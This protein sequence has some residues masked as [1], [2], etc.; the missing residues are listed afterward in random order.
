[1]LF[2]TVT[3]LLCKPNFIWMWK[4]LH[5]YTSGIYNAIG[6]KMSLFRHRPTVG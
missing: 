3:E 5:F 2:S 4:Q 6:Y 1:M